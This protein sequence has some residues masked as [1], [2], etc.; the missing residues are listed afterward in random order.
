MVTRMPPLTPLH[1]LAQPS[2]GN[3]IGDALLWG[4]VLIGTIVALFGIVVLYRKWM[5]RDDTTTGPGFTL[6]DLRRLHKEGKMTTEEFEKAKTILIGSVKAAADKPKEGP[7]TG[8]PGFDV[9]P[10]S[11]D[12]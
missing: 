9:L 8:P 3:G 6:S 2:S 4:I 10:P 5:N 1:L 12:A 7:R 11:G